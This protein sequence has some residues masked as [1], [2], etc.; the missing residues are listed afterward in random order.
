[1]SIPLTT[2]RLPA[3]WE[4]QSGVMLTWPHHQGF[5]AERFDQVEPVFLAIATA[6]ARRETL[7]LN[8][9]DPSQAAHVRQRLTDSGV[10]ESRLFF[11]LTASDDTWA[12]DHGPLTVMESDQPLLLDFHFNGWGNK[13]PAEQDD[14]INGHLAASGLFGESPMQRVELVLEGG[15]IDSDGCGTLL[16][17]ASCLLNPQRNPALTRGEIESR[18]KTLFGVDRLLWLEQGCIEGDDTDGHIDM[19]ARF[20]DAQTLVY[21]RCDDIEYGCYPALR[22]MEDELRAFR[23]RDGR[24]YRLVPLPWPQPKTSS[25]GERMPASYA[26]FLLVNGAVLLPVYRDPA[27]AIAVQQLQQCF[28]EREIVPIDCLPLIVQHGSLHC[29]TMQFPAAVRF[30]RTDG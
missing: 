16:T 10:D 22:A 13:Y 5:W 19:L 23:D 30:R 3:E 18:L 29:L 2:R 6:I 20:A 21:Q 25:A 9:S 11:H 15:S 7:L 4:P 14:A 26:N 8:C 24:P 17:T 28:P 27:D 1:M 12:R